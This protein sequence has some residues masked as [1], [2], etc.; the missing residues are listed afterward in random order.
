MDIMQFLEGISPW[1]W[2]AAALALG[3]IEMATMSF[4]L[5]WPA[6]AAL[7]VAGFLVVSPDLTGTAQIVVF[8]GLGILFT[9]IGRIL[10]SRM[11]TDGDQA[12]TLNQRGKM[13]EGRSAKVLDFTDGHGVVEV[14]GMRWQALWP[15]GETAQAGDTVRI[16]G[17]NGMVLD[18]K[19]PSA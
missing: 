7:C 11:G 10:M 3:A 8:A 19:S 14:A 1:W 12:S 2:V 17:A 13:L 18:V 5:I 15:E 6:L 9:V 4:F 16:T